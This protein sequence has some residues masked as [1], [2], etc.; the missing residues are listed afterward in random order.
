MDLNSGKMITRSRVTE[1]PIT[2]KIIK[3]LYHWNLMVGLVQENNLELR[4]F[5]IFS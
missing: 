4:M 2:E 5:V 1:I 3:V